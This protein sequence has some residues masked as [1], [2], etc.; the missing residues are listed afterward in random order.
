[1]GEREGGE[2]RRGRR[3]GKN[4]SGTGGGKGEGEGKGQVLYVM[5]MTCRTASLFL[6][7]AIFFIWSLHLIFTAS[8]KMGSEKKRAW[9]Y[10]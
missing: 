4:G 5:D 3:E 6:Y 9:H 2:G 1:M 7:T 8:A 10:R